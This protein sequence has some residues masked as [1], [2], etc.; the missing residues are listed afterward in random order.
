MASMSCCLRDLLCDCEFVG[1]YSC[2]LQCVRRWRLYAALE[3]TFRAARAQLL[4][5]RV[6]RPWAAL[7]RESA[8]DGWARQQTAALHGVVM[9]D[10]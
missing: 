5:G 2:V 4:G 3:R 1:R 9:D 7:A 8:Y 10:L 6:F